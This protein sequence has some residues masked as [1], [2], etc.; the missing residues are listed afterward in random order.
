MSPI[1]FRFEDNDFCL[2]CHCFFLLYFTFCDS[3][4]DTLLFHS[5]ALA[6]AADLHELR[7]GC[8]YIT[9]FHSMWYFIV[10]QIS[11]CL[12]IRTSSA[13]G[14]SSISPIDL[15]KGSLELEGSLIFF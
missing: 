8:F 6:S 3:E 1:L 7:K 5:A 9:F 11:G 2:S 12:S 13:V 14:G 4:S 15:L 10:V